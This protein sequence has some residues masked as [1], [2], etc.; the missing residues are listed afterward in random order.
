[1]LPVPLR[2]V[3][4]LL[5]QRARDLLET[6]NDTVDRIAEQ[7]GFGSARILPG[8]SAEAAC[9]LLHKALPRKRPATIA[10]NILLRR[11]LMADMRSIRTRSSID[12]AGSSGMPAVVPEPTGAR[13][14]PA[15][16]CQLRT[17]GSP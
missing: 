1:M 3:Q 13:L 5:R 9:A 2:G 17:V 4:Y 10:S 16:K 6:T 14:D 15:P 11:P 12:V 8:V 7:C